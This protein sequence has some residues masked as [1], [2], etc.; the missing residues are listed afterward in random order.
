MHS[1]AADI[2]WQDPKIT[3][4]DRHRLNKHRSFVLWFTGLSASG[5]STLAM[6]LE[7]E[8]Y[9]RGIR[10]YVLDGDNMR[11]SLNK[12]LGFGLE[13]RKE[14]IRRIG[15]VAKLFVDAGL[16]ALAA[17]IS[18]YQ[19]DRAKVRSMFGNGEFIEIYVKCS[20]EECQRRDPK[21]LYK[22][23][24]IGEI[25][26]FTGIS[27]PYEEP[28]SPEMVIESDMISIEESI[29]KT[30]NYLSGLGYL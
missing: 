15:E 18:P 25:P 5:K 14:N 22:R 23:A 13:D 4:E 28:P 19:E 2:V 21:G 12:D 17:C 24:R 29:K 6:E 9:N 27:A 16:I 20:L 8:L 11:H 30:V 26:Q 7:K 3:K 1:L 10:S